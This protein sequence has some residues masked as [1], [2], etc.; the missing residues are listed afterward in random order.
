MLYSAFLALLLFLRFS[1]VSAQTL[2][3]MVLESQY[4]AASGV[5]EISNKRISVSAELSADPV[6]LVRS[7]AELK[8]TGSLFDLSAV[9]AETVI[10][11]EEGGTLTIDGTELSGWKAL[12]DAVLIKSSGGTIRLLNHTRFT[13]NTG[14]TDSHLV[15]LKA[16]QMNITESEFRDN[17]EFYE[18]MIIAE[19][20]DVLIEK[21]QHFGK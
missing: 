3:P 14:E 8:I 11:V 7:G 13:G 5:S 16:G 10:R 4:V 18:G 12:R 6:I 20:A 2:Q 15:S 17:T 9:S 1:G 21:K 19:D